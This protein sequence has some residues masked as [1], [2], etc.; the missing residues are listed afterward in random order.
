[1]AGGVYRGRQ[2]VEEV[3]PPLL[4]S[5]TSERLV[6]GHSDPLLVGP[7]CYELIGSNAEIMVLALVGNTLKHVAGSMPD[8]EIQ[9][10]DNVNT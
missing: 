3:D 8:R 10:S 9:G 6:L 2:S 5:E 1:M 7:T 4:A